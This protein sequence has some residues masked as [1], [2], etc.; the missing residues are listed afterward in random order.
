MRSGARI[1]RKDPADDSGDPVRDA[2]HSI[3]QAIRATRLTAVV[4]A[5][6]ARNS[7]VHGAHDVRHRSRGMR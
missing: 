5:F 7:A 6:C 1:A 3:V 2:P 4:R